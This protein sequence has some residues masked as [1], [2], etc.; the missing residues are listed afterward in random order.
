MYKIVAL[1]IDGTLLD[2]NRGISTTTNKTLR[3]VSKFAHV[4]LIS[5][6][7]PVAMSYL[8]KECGISDNPIV[9]FNGGLILHKESVLSSTG[10]DFDTF[11]TIN[12]LNNDLDLHLSL[13]HNDEWY[14]PMDD[15]WSQREI[16][17]TRVNPVYKSNSQVFEK[18]N[19]EDKR[20]HKI[21]CMGDENKVD[22]FFNRL[23]K[24][25]G[26][27]LHLYRS[28]PTYIEIA[29]KQIS[30]LSGLEVLLENIYKDLNKKDIIAY[31]DNY[32]D[33][34]MLEN[35]GMGVAVANAKDEVKSIAKEMTDSNINDGVAKH[36]QKI[37]RLKL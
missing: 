14:A 36:L 3:A 28:K 34:E 25:A 6:R 23:S 5:S 30:K 13:F 32:N 35:V 33:I 8:Q 26:N 12:R 10:I 15:F 27:N 19:A 2:K 31:G 22:E 29:P 7:M 1:D 11:K 18:W 37:F 24:E 20:P 4:V 16:R 9:A 17:N 21:M